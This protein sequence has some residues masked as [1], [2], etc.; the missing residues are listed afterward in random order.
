[1]FQDGTK[2][3]ILFEKSISEMDYYRII[4][5]KPDNDVNKLQQKPA[6]KHY[7]H[8]YSALN[9]L[10]ISSTISLFFQSSFHLSLT[11][12]VHYRSFEHI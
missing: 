2:R 8:S 12:L 7:H 10:T 3:R 5:L 6:H 4:Q 11:V 1:M 9:L